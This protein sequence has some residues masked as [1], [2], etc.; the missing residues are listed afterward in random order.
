[1]IQRRAFALLL[2]VLLALPAL[3]GT[4]QTP[5]ASG[6]TEVDRLPGFQAGVFRD[7]GPADTFVG[8]ATSIANA[9]PLSADQ[10]DEGQVH[11]IAMNVF[12]FDTARNAGVAFDQLSAEAEES[13]G[14]FQGGTREITNEDPPDVG[15]RAT[16]ARMD[17]ASEISRKWLEYVTVQR[18]QYVFVV[19]SDAS[20]FIHTPGSDPAAPT[21]PTVPLA[22]AIAAGEPSPDEPTFVADGASTGGLWGFLPAS[23]D[24]L[25]MG[26]VPLSDSV[27]YPRP[28][29]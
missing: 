16:L 8:S 17:Y 2:T 9:T 6:A 15:T 10:L 25:L 5:T 11:W 13:F 29:E 28:P 7:Y 18:D 12:E 4:A 23:D 14:A 1:M 27:L 20:A 22:T 24:P 26:L 19:A 21:L 3:S